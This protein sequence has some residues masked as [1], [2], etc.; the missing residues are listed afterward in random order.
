MSQPWT[1]EFDERMRAFAGGRAGAGIGLSIKVR[2][3]SGCF[4][5]EHSPHAY[6]IIDRDLAA[7]TQ[8]NVAADVLEHESGPELLLWLAAGTAV[9]TLAKS[10]VDLAV[11]ILKARSKGIEKGDHPRDPLDIIVRRSI[12]KESVKD[13]YILRIG[14][15]DA[16]DESRLE[17]L[18]E[19]A[20]RRLSDLGDP[21][22]PAG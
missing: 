19:D 17:R 11:V 14:H 18:V 16:I 9:A 7:R 22:K 8:S 15:Q 3:S 21:P 6:A 2:V 13:E 4:H 10:I 12:G 5:R 1:S 20:V